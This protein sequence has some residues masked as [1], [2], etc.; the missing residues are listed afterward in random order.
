MLLDYLMD[1][2][3]II[4]F[5]KAQDKLDHYLVLLYQFPKDFFLKY[6]LIQIIESIV[7]RLIQH[8]HH[9]NFV[10]LVNEEVTRILY[11]HHSQ[12]VF[13]LLFCC[14]FPL[15]Y[16]SSKNQNIIY[17]KLFIYQLKPNH[18]LNFAHQACIHQLNHHQI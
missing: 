4:I 2:K 7:F 8:K 6:F 18:L 12:I 10:L 16:F 5:L 15:I 1:L 14:Y 13:H 17:E 9:Q 11:Y 3:I